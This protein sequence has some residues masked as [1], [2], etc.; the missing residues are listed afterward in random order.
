M[1]L[2]TFTIPYHLFFENAITLSS[3]EFYS[4]SDIESRKDV[5]LATTAEVNFIPFIHTWFSYFY[6]YDDNLSG[7]FIYWDVFAYFKAFCWF[8]FYIIIGRIFSCF[9]DVL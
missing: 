4:A 7:S 9:Y 8:L 3:D 6:I 1:V 5:F 2:I